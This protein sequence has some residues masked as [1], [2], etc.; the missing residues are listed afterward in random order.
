MKALPKNQY[1]DFSGHSMRHRARSRSF[2]DAARGNGGCV[3]ASTHPRFICAPPQGIYKR[4]TDAKLN[5]VFCYTP[6]ASR[7]NRSK[8]LTTRVYLQS[9]HLAQIWLRG[10][11]KQDW[12]RKIDA[13]DTYL[14]TINCDSKS[15]ILTL[16]IGR[17]STSRTLL[18][19]SVVT[20]HFRLE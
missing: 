14:E 11:W 8:D 15:K 1:I 4:A 5:A 2:A 18:L 10:I 20:H 6:Y 19:N 16:Y 9:T 17:H 13:N 7:R 12:M 3:P